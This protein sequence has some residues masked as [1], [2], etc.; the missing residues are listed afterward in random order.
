MVKS[1]FTTL[2]KQKQGFLTSV[3]M[4]LIIELCVTFLIVYQ[5]RNHPALAKVTK[6][7]FWMYLLLSIG[8]ILILTLVSMPVWLKFIVFTLFAA[9]AGGMLYQASYRFPAELITQSLMGTIGV[10]IAMTF[11]AV[12]LAAMGVDLSFLG[13]ILLAA[14]L[15]LIVASL[16][17]ILM[18]TPKTSKLHKTLLIIGL[19]LFSIYITYST[20]IMLQ[21]NYNEDFI[22][23][24]IDLYLNFINVFARI[25]ALEAE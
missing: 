5:F 3:Y 2:I 15:G 21:K 8:L 20:N 9:V 23:A 17:V 16:I 13:V 1:S 4:T 7:S 12:I 6:Q 10:F 14:L 18:S 25:F 11:L 19:V 22:S 24:A